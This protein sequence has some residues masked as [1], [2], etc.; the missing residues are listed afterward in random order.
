VPSSPRARPPKSGSAV[1]TSRRS[2]SP[3]MTR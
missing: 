2:R 1:P 3:S